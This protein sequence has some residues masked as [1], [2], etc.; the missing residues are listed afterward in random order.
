MS[1]VIALDVHLVRG[2]IKIYFLTCVSNAFS[3]A[4]H[5]Y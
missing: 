1:Y 3:L 2:T 4:S 5:P